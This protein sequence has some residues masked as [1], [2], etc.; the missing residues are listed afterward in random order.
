[1]RRQ[2]K[3]LRSLNGQLLFAEFDS[4]TLTLDCVLDATRGGPVGPVTIAA[5]FPQPVTTPI[6]ALHLLRRWADEAAPVEITI[7]DE[8]AGAHVEI[9]APSGRVVLEPAGA[10]QG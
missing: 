9:S 3:P 8:H 2:P 4:G 6:D 7:A 10:P 5:H 1:M